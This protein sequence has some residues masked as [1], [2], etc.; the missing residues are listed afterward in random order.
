MYANV[1]VSDFIEDINLNNM[2]RL[3]FGA[4]PLEYLSK[5]V[6]ALGG[7]LQRKHGSSDVLDCRIVE[8]PNSW[9]TG[10]VICYGRTLI[11]LLEVLIEYEKF[12]SIEIALGNSSIYSGET[13][14]ARIRVLLK[15]FAYVLE[16]TGRNEVPALQDLA[17]EKFLEE[18]VRDFEFSIPKDP[19]LADFLFFTKTR[20]EVV[21][22]HEAFEK[23]ILATLAPVSED[24][25]NLFTV[26]NINWAETWD[27]VGS[28]ATKDMLWFFEKN[29]IDTNDDYMLD[30][31]RETFKKFKRR[32]FSTTLI[33]SV[34]YW[35]EVGDPP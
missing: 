1:T 23:P 33:G 11:L 25:P 29:L 13:D 30:L 31:L 15:R 4:Y 7:A 22:A 16:K 17:G 20:E 3:R 19:F 32:W 18:F 34:D 26:D 27:D 10:P 2:V 28:N 21:K 14:A 24:P 35:F 9:S 12:R 6:S 5:V 8:K